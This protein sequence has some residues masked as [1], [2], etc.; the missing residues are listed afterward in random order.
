MIK[1]N[2]EKLIIKY[3]INQINSDEL[4]ILNSWLNEKESNKI[5]FKHYI[6]TNY[7]IEHYKSVNASNLKITWSTIESKIKPNKRKR[8]YWKY[9]AAASVM[10]FISLSILFIKNREQDIPSNIITTTPPTLINNDIEIG[11]KKATLTLEDGSNIFLEKGKDFVSNNLK[12]DDKGI[13]YKGA[14]VSKNKIQYN[15]LTIP[16]GGE[17]S[18]KLPDGSQVWLNSESQLK[19]PVAFAKGEPRK[20]ELVYGEAYFKV[21]PSTNHDGSKF[22]VNTQMQEIEVL[23][24]EFN[25]NAYKDE[26]YIYTTLVEG[27]IAIN[28]SLNMAIL[29]PGDQSEINIADQNSTI[30]ITQ[31]NVKKIISWKKGIFTFSNLP[32]KEIAKVLSR[33]YDV[34]IIF[35]NKELE[36]IRF[37]GVSSKKQNIEEILINIRNTN[38]INNYKI[39]GKTIFIR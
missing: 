3:C 35:A 24:T 17:F 14:K 31:V 4:D 13:V 33:W 1:S 2:I 36:D 16:R 27:S 37:N 18:I 22:I 6:V 39:D 23:G 8:S 38:F 25:I 30:N 19:Y 10:L 11:S 20:V 34:D 28:N 32:L 9:A 12:A 26:P 15:Y 21:S 29:K 7:S 5:I